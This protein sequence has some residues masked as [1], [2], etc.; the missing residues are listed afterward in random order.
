MFGSYSGP[1][2]QFDGCFAAPG[3]VG[4]GNSPA[5]E[6]AWSLLRYG[7]NVTALESITPVGHAGSATGEPL[8]GFSGTGGLAVVPGSATSGQIAGP[9]VGSV[10]VPVRNP[11]QLLF[12]CTG[13]LLAVVPSGAVLMTPNALSVMLLFSMLEAAAPAS[14]TPAPRCRFSLPS[15]RLPR[16]YGSLSGVGAKTLCTGEPAPLTKLDETV[17]PVI[18]TE[19]PALTR[20]PSCPNSGP[21]VKGSGGGIG[22]PPPV[23]SQ[24]PS[25]TVGPPAVGSL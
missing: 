10:T 2:V 25:M 4:I 18:W 15:V 20:T 23:A 13:M 3:A 1:L 22:V 9:G 24:S 6:S 14:R 17:S 7:Q 19:A 5:T 8:T 12:A 21:V 16:G 11:H